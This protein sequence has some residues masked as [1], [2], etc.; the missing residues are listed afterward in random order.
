[1]AS[2]EGDLHALPVQSRGQ[3]PLGGSVPVGGQTS[4]RLPDSQRPRSQRGRHV[5]STPESSVPDASDGKR[6]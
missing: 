1:M 4:P 5:S 2:R 6:F 3:S